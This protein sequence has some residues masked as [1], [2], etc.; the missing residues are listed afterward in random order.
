MS[1]SASVPVKR[2]FVQVQVTE[3]ERQALE[4]MAFREAQRK[5]KRR[6]GMSNLLLQSLYENNK[7]F[8]KLVRS[9]EARK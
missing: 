2:Q 4:V 3:P 8:G 5:G 6:F 7:Q 1:Q 9:Y